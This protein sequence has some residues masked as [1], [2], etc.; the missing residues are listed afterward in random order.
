MRDFLQIIQDR[1]STRAPVD[2]KRQ[3]SANELNGMQ[4]AR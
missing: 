1:Q 4:A 2:P 3:I